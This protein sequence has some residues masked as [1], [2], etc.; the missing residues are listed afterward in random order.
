MSIMSV[1]GPV[2]TALPPVTVHFHE[3]EESIALHDVTAASRSNTTCL[4]L[5]QPPLMPTKTSWLPPPALRFLAQSAGS[6][7][8]PPPPLLPPPLPPLPP[9]LPPLLPPPSLPPVDPVPPLLGA[10]A[11][12]AGGGAAA[13][14]GL[15]DEATGGGVPGGACAAG[16]TS[17]PRRCSPALPAASSVPPHTRAVSA[18]PRPPSEPRSAWPSSA[19]SAERDAHAAGVDGGVSTA[20]WLTF[21][22]LIRGLARRPVTRT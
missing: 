3:L 19:L 4:K 2:A 16:G 11:G 6:G 15:G 8:V 5:P 21:S 18:G 13:G 1:A 7:F 10:P 22:P 14:A 17:R 20:P 9:L 12:A